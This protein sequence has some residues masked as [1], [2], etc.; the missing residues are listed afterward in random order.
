[1]SI[2]I[3]T[4]EAKDVPLLADAFFHTVWK[5]QAAYFE[6]ILAEQEKENRIILV[7]Y[8]GGKTAGF[9][10]IIWNSKHPPFA[11]KNIPEINDLRVLEQ[12]RRRGIATALMD[13]AERRIFERFPITGIGV[14]L[15]ADYGPAQRMYTRRGYILDGRGLTYKNTPVPPGTSV[16]V[17]DNLVI[18]LTKKRP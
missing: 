9:L 18:Y 13:E 5:T 8:S 15:Y 10:N 2:T 1:M 7:A 17:D 14:G 6:S 3:K 4:L 16:L 12:F 11:E